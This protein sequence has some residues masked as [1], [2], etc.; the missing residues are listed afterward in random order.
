MASS[1]C[2]SMGLAP[3]GLWGKVMA[4][5]Q[6]HLLRALDEQELC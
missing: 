3:L 5:A 4:T 1:G 2:G 6:W